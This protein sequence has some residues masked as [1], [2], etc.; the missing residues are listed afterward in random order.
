MPPSTAFPRQGDWGHPSLTKPTS[1][2]EDQKPR[3]FPFG[4]PSPEPPTTPHTLIHS[5][6]V[7][8]IPFL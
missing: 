7:L 4:L 3:P 8:E 5:V 6:D 2:L 1:P